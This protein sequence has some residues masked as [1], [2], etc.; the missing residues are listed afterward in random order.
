MQPWSWSEVSV[1]HGARGSEEGHLVWRRMQQRYRTDR[2]SCAP[3]EP[4]PGMIM[5]KDRPSID[6]QPL[7]KKIISAGILE[8]DNPVRI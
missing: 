7:E 5:N 1:R 4:R 8:D 2:E 3:L 6:T